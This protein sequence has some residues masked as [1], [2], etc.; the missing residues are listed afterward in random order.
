[1]I[2]KFYGER[3]IPRSA[4]PPDSTLP[5]DDGPPSDHRPLHSTM[6]SRPI[7]SPH[8]LYSFCNSSSKSHSPISPP[9]HAPKSFRV[10]CTT[11]LQPSLSSSESCSLSRATHEPQAAKHL[12]LSSPSSRPRF[13]ENAHAPSNSFSYFEASS[14]QHRTAQLQLS[15]QPPLS[16]TLQSSIFSF[17]STVTILRYKCCTPLNSCCVLS[18]T[19]YSTFFVRHPHAANDE[20]PGPGSGPSMHRCSS[21]HRMELGKGY[22]ASVRCAGTR[23]A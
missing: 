6:L 1:M 12:N 10:S 14:A 2:W 23:T 17:F 18:K 4:I 15:D 21:V 19:S 9:Y 8:Q 16:S 22:G 3:G 13:Q 7:G 20:V 11:T 5:L